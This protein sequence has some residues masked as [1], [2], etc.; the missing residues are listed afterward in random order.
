M[1]SAQKAISNEHILISGKEYYGTLE[2]IKPSP[3]INGYRNKCEFTVGFNVDNQAEVGFRIS[4]YRDGGYVVVPI[5]DCPHVPNMVKKFVSHFVSFVRQSDRPAYDVIRKE[6]FWKMLTTK[7]FKFDFMVIVTVNPQFVSADDMNR[8]KNVLVEAFLKC[9]IELGYRITSLF[10]SAVVNQSDSPNYEHI[11]GVPYVYET[12]LGCR[13]RISP[14]TFFQTNTASCEVLYSTLH[15]LTKLTKETLLLDI[16]CGAGTIGITMA[17]R[18]KKV[19]G[20]ELVDEAVVDARVNAVCNEKDNCQF[21]SG[22][23]EDVF[24][25]FRRT[26]LIDFDEY[27]NVVAVLDPP[28]KGLGDKIVSCVRECRKISSVIYVSCDPKAATKNFLDLCRLTSNR[29]PGIGFKLVTVVPV[30]MFP[31]TSHFEWLLLFQREN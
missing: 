23:A 6:G 11:G 7:F 10:L 9:N 8:V 4:R 5:D 2:K 1:I 17:D 15:T 21:I 18:V 16:C 14:A 13:F 31:H 26:K 24:E 30:D 28:R 20:I 27:D 22:K 25:S 3:I 19:V 29:Y 12:L